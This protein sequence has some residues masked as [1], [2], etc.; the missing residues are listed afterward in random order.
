MFIMN[1]LHSYALAARMV[2]AGM[3]LLAPCAVAKAQPP[4]WNS[5]AYG[6][7]P[8]VG[9]LPYGANYDHAASAIPS[10]PSVIPAQA[11][12]RGPLARLIRNP[13]AMNG[14]PPYALADQAG[15]I[16]RYVEPMPGVDLESHI[17]RVV[18]VR[19]DTGRTLLASQLELPPVSLYPLPGSSQG[20]D[21]H[22]DVTNWP[23]S[24]AGRSSI[25]PVQFA[26]ND[27]HTVELLPNEEELPG[28]SANQSGK[29][30]STQPLPENWSRRDAAGERLR[31]EPG[32][33]P[34]TLD[35]AYGPLELIDPHTGM[36]DCN[37]CPH[38]QGPQFPPDYSPPFLAA[39]PSHRMSQ[40]HCRWYADF[41]LNFIRT[42]LSDFVF[43]KLSEKYEL[44]PR[45][46][47]GYQDSG[48]LDGRVR[49]WHYGQDTPVLGNSAVNVELDVMDIEATHGFG[50]KTAQFMIGGGLRLAGIDLTQDGASAGADLLGMTFFID[51]CTPL[52]SLEGGRFAWI[53]GGR[54]SILGG[55]WGGDSGSLLAG[56]LMQDDNVVVHELHTGLD[57]AFCYEDVDFH[58]RAGFE[59]QNWHSDALSQNAGVD[60]IGF[61]G[62]GIQFG[63]AF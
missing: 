4:G 16:Q 57:Y 48:L 18:V 29:A 1:S 60:S 36:M 43:G 52:W 24:S 13:N 39:R 30:S 2:F 35:S 63:A 31:V 40:P 59:M 55:D 33:S 50:G 56:G 42:H 11:P 45:V 49:Y 26:D 28:A 54:L 46:I 38:C 25:Q 10:H 19:H 6:L 9:P 21:M 17:D 3:L 32:M 44:S 7:L 34:A 58:V 23:T 5:A 8:M 27:D 47:V 51:G 14:L 61:I 12:S 15:R 53:Y 62:P 22:V 20:G 37:D 41:E